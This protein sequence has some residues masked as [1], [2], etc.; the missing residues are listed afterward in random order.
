L[1][2]IEKARELERRDLDPAEGA[3]VYDTSD[4]DELEK[5]IIDSMNAARAVEPT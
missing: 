4:I 5:T 1:R 3:R 2:F